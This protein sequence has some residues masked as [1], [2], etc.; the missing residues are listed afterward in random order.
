MLQ[1]LYSRGKSPQ[2]PMNRR[3][4]RPQSQ[5]GHFGGQK[6]PLHLPKFEFH[7]IQPIS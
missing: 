7:I 1:L 6:N 3:V 2:Y 5:S 4:D